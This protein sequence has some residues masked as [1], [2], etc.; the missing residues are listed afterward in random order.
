MTA[1]DE[2][3][4]Q[5]TASYGDKQQA[6]Q[7]AKKN[8]GGNLLVADLNDVLTEAEM[9]KVKVHNTDYLKTVFIAVPKVAQEA[10]EESIYTIGDKIVGYG[11]E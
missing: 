5:L 9:R 7:E 11:G 3:L 4:K 1:V 6:L 8:K 10:F 2:E